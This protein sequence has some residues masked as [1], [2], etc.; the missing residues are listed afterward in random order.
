MQAIQSLDE[1]YQQ[2]LSDLEASYIDAI[3]A[4]I[5]ANIQTLDDINETNAAAFED[6]LI[7]L[8]SLQTNLQNSQYSI[9]QIS[10]IVE[11]LDNQDGINMSEIDALQQS[12]QN[13]QSSLQSSIYDL[14][15]RLNNTR[16]MNDFSYLDFKDAELFNFNNGLGV[17]MD[18]PIFNFANLKNASLGYSNFSDASFV[19]AN[20]RSAEGIFSTF[21][22]AD[23][24]NAAMSFGI[25]R[26]SDFTDA[27][28]VGAQL[29]YTEFRY[30]D[31][32]GVNLTNAR[33]YGGGDWLMV[34][35]SYADLTNAMMYDLDLRYAN[36]TGADL[37]AA[38]LAYLNTSYGPADLTGV[39]WSNTT[40]P[41]GTNSD[42]NGNTCMNNL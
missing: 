3:E 10:F 31:M 41:D 40:C 2:S 8:N 12:L 5:L 28:F 26:Q 11:D 20:L 29:A 32:S 19:N 27:Q 15:N 35:L 37:T 16:A 39:T 13:L 7:S 9:D 23:F 1:D 30:S 33:I 24:S 6:L 18:P 17:Q 34:D 22:R 42:N 14:E 21:H 25:F 36:L 4:L 38:D